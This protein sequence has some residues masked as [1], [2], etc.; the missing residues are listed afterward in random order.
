MHFKLSQTCHLSTTE[1]SVYT[2]ASD[3]VYVCVRVCGL[4]G[5][6]GGECE[7]CSTSLCQSPWEK[8]T[9]LA[10]GEN[11]GQVCVCVCVCVCVAVCARTSVCVI[12]MC[13]PS[14]LS[15]LFTSLSGPTHHPQSSE[16]NDSAGWS[17]R[18]VN[19]GSYINVMC[20][21]SL[22]QSIRR[23][24]SF[25]TLLHHAPSWYC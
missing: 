21:A 16:P 5:G 13:P 6:G 19:T 2:C 22:S 25:I 15:A 12:H 7:C 3:R 4:D 23:D 18:Q 9:V 17:P 14:F 11:I 20:S 1:K 24:K 8:Q 10:A